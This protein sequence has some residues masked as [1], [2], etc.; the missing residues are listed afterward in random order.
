[1]PNYRSLIGGFFS[2]TPLDKSS[3]PVTIRT[4]NPGA[5]NGAPWET[6]Y[7]GYVGT[8]VTTPG[9]PSS[10]FEAPEYGVG[11]WWNLMQIYETT[12]TNTVAGIINRYGGQ[13]DYSAYIQFVVKR[14]GFAPDTVVDLSDDQQLLGF[15][16]AMFRYEA[17]QDLPWNSDQILFGIRCGRDGQWPV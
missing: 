1:M 10:I 14:T 8:V 9:N 3:G 6:S 4:N 12:N 5:I 2:S 17:G 13:Q 11:A 15:G 7:P 16:S